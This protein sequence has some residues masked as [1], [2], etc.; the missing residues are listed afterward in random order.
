MAEVSI[1]IHGRDYGITC[2]EGQESRVMELG[3]FVDDKVGDM[4][5]A[6]AAS[7]DTQLL[8]LASI[9][10]AD[11]LFD[12]RERLHSAQPVYT[13]DAQA[14]PIANE[15]EIAHGIETLAERINGIADKVLNG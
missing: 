3:R 6:G 1:N 4:A 15:N 12:L 2:D 8:V 9:L 14:A 7:N 13:E 11:E 10:M 5:A